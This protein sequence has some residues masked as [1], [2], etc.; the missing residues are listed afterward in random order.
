MTV[1]SDQTRWRIFSPRLMAR[2]RAA[3]EVAE[4]VAVV[5]ALQLADE[6]GGVRVV[7]P[8]TPAER[9]LISSS[10]A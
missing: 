1:G 2:P 10:R 9:N 3:A 5:V 7:A 6:V 8:R 4:S